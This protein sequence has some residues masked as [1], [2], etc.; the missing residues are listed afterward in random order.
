MTVPNV[1]LL[2]T[3]TQI[4]EHDCN[5]ACIEESRCRRDRYKAMIHFDQA[6]DFSRM[7]YKITKSKKT[8]QLQDV[9]VTYEVPAKLLRSTKQSTALLLE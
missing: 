2:D 1:D 5:C 7:S 8:P 9:P 4:T 3:V 6:H